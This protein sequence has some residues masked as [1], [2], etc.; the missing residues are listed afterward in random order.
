MCKWFLYMGVPDSQIGSYNVF[1]FI[2]ISVIPVLFYRGFKNIASGISLFTY[3]LL[4]IPIIYATRI[5]PDTYGAL[6]FSM[7]LLVLMSFFFI[8]DSRVI[9]LNNGSGKK[10]PFKVIEITTLFIVLFVVFLEGRSLKFVNILTSKDELYDLRASYGESRLAITG[11]LLSWCKYAFLPMLVVYYL[12]TQSWIKY[13]L[14]IVGFIVIFMFDMLKVT[15][16][17]P[18]L[19]TAVYYAINNKNVTYKMLPYVFLTFIIGPLVLY[20]FI[21]NTAVFGI[22]A[23]MIMRTQCI[24]T[25]LSSIYLQFFSGHEYTYYTHINIINFLSNN[26]YPYGNVPL[27]IAVTE[28]G[29]NANASFLLTDGYAAMGLVGVVLAGL[30]FILFKTILNGVSAIFDKNMVVLFM[31]S[32][33]TAMLN[34]SLFTAI[35]SCGFLIFYLCMVYV[36]LSVFEKNNKV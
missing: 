30:F 12:R 16:V 11:Y 28:G 26:A 3:L 34:V 2:L 1:L 22:A 19:L 13:A 33:I 20:A 10:I 18:I 25:W 21:D 36:D 8:T 23:I 6:P 32:A 7:V 17:M 5:I 4:Y 29:M 14:S 35:F 24:E 27:G 9:L 31:F 15:F